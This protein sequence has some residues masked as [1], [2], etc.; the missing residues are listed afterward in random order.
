MRTHLTHWLIIAVA[1]SCGLS[2]SPLVSAEPEAKPAMGWQALF[3]GKTLKNWEQ[4]QFGGEGE[5]TIEDGRIVMQQGA[6]LTGLHWK[7]DPLPKVNYELRLEAQRIDGSDFFCGI[8]FPH[9]D[10]YCSFV[11]GGWG[12]GVVGLSSVDGIYASENETASYQN[13]KSKTWYKIRLRVG[14]DFVAA[15]IDDEPMVNLELTGRKLSV[16]PAVAVAKPLG[17]C[18]FSTVAGLRNIEFRELPEAE[19]ARPKP[20]EK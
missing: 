3:D 19:R 17:I 18:C 10:E 8:I 7:G 16:H 14:T 5:I 6:E 15:W 2:S 9:A 4:T 11:V 13:F 1:L 20:E 12:G